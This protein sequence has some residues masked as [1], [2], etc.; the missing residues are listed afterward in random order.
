MA[1]F[2]N[3]RLSKHFML[4][5]FMG[6]HS[7]ITKGL[8]NVFDP[9]DE[10]R[11][12]NATALCEMLLEPVLVKHGSMSISYGYISPDVSRQ[13][14]TYMDPDAPSH[15][16][17]DLGAAADICVHN[18]VN[19]DPDDDTVETAPIMLAHEIANETPFSRMITYSESP[20][21]CAAVSAYEVNSGNP[22]RA[23]YENRYSG[24]ARAKPDYRQL[25]S[26]MARDRSHMELTDG[27]LAHGWRGA[28]HPTYHGG[29]RRQFQHIRVSKY[30]MMSDWLMDLQSIANGARNIPN[31]GHNRLWE[32]FCAVGDAYDEL[33]ELNNVNRMTIVAG[34]VSHTNPYFDPANDWRTGTAMFSVIPP[35]GMSA[36]D[37]RLSLL[38]GTKSHI[39]GF[40]SS[41]HQLDI[42]VTL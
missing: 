4:S 30:S 2:Q 32:M 6:N 18:W 24:R 39:T 33:L 27:G 13:I 11:M 3:I 7:V 34:Y 36:A 31:M 28:G 23:F 1:D 40:G 5:D 21:I 37:V 9:T 42:T 15:H 16:R 22:R 35:E 25:K 10:H 14:V 17:W 41:D 20:Y 26:G 19:S 38:F 8:A 12:N 29:G